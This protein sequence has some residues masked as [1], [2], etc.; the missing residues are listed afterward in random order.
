MSY[1]IGAWYVMYPDGSLVPCE[2][3]GTARYLVDNGYAVGVVDP[4]KELML[5]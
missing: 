2:N 3:Y 5:S 1:I 4:T